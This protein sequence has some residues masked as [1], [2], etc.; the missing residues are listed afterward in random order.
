[1]DLTAKETAIIQSKLM[2]QKDY[3]LALKWLET[4]GF[5]LSVTTYYDNLRR[6]NKSGAERLFHIGQQFPAFHA[7]EIEKFLLIESQ[8]YE[9]YYQEREPLNKARILKMIADIQ[10]LI[11]SLY[12]STQYVLETNAK[13]KDILSRR[14]EK[15][16]VAV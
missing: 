15:P 2:F 5:K 12:D 1:M 8:L 9:Q 3:Q 4:K 13:F 11:T 6:L 7:D 14:E 10:P 16:T